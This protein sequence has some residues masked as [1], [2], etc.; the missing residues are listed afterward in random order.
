MLADRI[1]AKWIDAFCEIFERC[2][3]KPGDT[4]AIL[5]ETQSRALNVHLAELALLRMGAKP[6]HII[7]PTPR[8]REAVPIRSTGASIAIQRLGP[9]V[10]ALQQAGFVVDC[11]I[12]GLMHA[13]ETPEILKAGAR[14]LNISNEHPEAL[15]RM[16]PDLALEKRVRAAAKMLRGTKRMRVTSKAGTDL[17]VDM[18]GASTV[19]VWGWTDRPGTLAHWPG[20][21]VVSF[22]KSGTVNGT[23]VMAAGDINLTFKRYLTSPIKMTLKDD[24]VTD[25]EGEGADAVMMRAYLAAWG[26]REAYAVS[27][28]GWGMNPGARYEALTMYDQR[29]TNGTELRA[30]SGNFLFSTGANEFA[31]RHTAGHF[32]LPM[33]GTTIELDGVAVVR[34][35]VLQDVSAN[36]D[37]APAALRQA[38]MPEQFDHRRE[39]LL[40]MGIDI[41]AGI[42]EEAGAGAHA[43]AALLH[44]ARDHLGR[45]VAVAAKGALEIAAGVIE[46]IAAAPIDELQK[47]QH[48]VAEAEAVPDRLVD[49]LGAGD[50]FLHHPRRLVHGERL[51][52]RHD[53]AGRGRAHHRHLADAL[54]QRFD[55]RDD[56]RIGRRARRNLDQRD[57]IGR[58]E[59]V[60]IEE[61]LGALDRARDIVD[62]DGRCGRSDDRIGRD[63]FRGCGQHLALEVDHLGHALE[64]DAGAGERRRHVL[65]RRDGDAGDHRIGVLVGQQSEPR[66]ACERLPDFAQCVGFERC[67]LFRGAGLDVD[68]G[69]GVAGI[70]KRNRDAATHAAGAETGNHGTG[71]GHRPNPSRNRFCNSRRPRPPRPR[72]ASVRPPFKKSSPQIA[73]PIAR[74]ALASGVATPAR[75]AAETSS[76]RPRR[77]SSR[78]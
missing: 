55:V 39:A 59:P 29:D 45:T 66:K 74:K 31:G 19:G 13:A 57:Q 42:I 62:Q 38:E 12:E 16:V 75:S 41:E 54:E 65:R 70:G 35:G 18:V 43:D 22:P 77:R 2:A 17:D 32:D 10:T 26:D 64:H 50:A 36:P 51:D 37:P 9:V 6:F 40:A 58:V 3:V 52:P 48:R 73:P 76:D 56:G 46:N 33:M 44:V 21:I 27:H 61:A 69:D 49:I 34:E 23:L 7:V 11:T 14:I 25:L 5:S 8:N 60:H 71:R 78:M 47:A 68:H 15:E 53:E 72:L 28:V 24:Y 30:V 63:A 1:E 4:A 20:G 67:E